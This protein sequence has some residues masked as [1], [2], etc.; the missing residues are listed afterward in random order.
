M[1]RFI[2][3]DPIAQFLEDREGQPLRASQVTSDA[4]HHIFEKCLILHDEYL[5]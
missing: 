2:R 4:P 3:R 5:P 1:Q